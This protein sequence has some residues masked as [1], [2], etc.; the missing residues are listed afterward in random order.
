MNISKQLAGIAVFITI[1]GVTIFLLRPVSAPVVN[2][3]LIPPPPPAAISASQPLNYQVQTVYLNL[4]NRKS[5][6]T[7]RLK[8]DVVLPAPESIWVRT[9]FFS[10]DSSTRHNWS[11]EPVEIRQP[12]ANGDQATITATANCD[13]CNE[14]GAPRGG[15]YARVHISTVSKEAARLRD[16]ML[17]A[18]ITTATPVL[19][20]TE[21]KQTTGQ[22]RR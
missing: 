9:S 11:S 12:F 21:G 4:V 18:D 19:I 7:L 10:T 14:A 16:D 13:W 5:Y 1:I 17:N 6:T 8:R 15:Y 22:P 3:P 2:P 20:Q